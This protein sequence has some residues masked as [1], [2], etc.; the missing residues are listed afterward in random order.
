MAATDDLRAY[1]LPRDRT[2]SSRLQSQ[3]E[4]YKQNLG[5][6]LH[7]T[8]ASSL[9]ADAAIADVGTGT[10]AWLLDVTSSGQK[11]WSFTGLDISTAQFPRPHS[12]N[13]VFRTMN[14]LEEIPDELRGQFDV[15]H[16]RLLLC[17]LTDPDWRLAASNAFQLLKPGGWLQWCEGDFAHMEVLQIRKGASRE[18]ILKL[19]AFDWK[20]LRKQGKVLEHT[21]RDLL[22]TVRQV[23][24]EECVQDVVSSDRDVSIRH[25]A[26]MVEQGA[27]SSIARSLVKSD[28]GCGLT[29]KDVER[30]CEESDREQRDGDVYWRWN[31]HVVIGRR[32]E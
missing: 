25:K 19:M 12:Q 17:G 27:M 15:V 22:Q 8:I 11:G 16:M 5:Y 14:I 24:F 2:E 18:A 26:S 20:L 4:V 13:C 32:P 3:H 9:P 23:G 10:G 7:P 6:V 1:T 30:L 28:P 21:I 29:T 31:I